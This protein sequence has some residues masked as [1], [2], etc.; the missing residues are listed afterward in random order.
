MKYII[1]IFKYYK[2]KRWRWKW[3][4]RFYDDLYSEILDRLQKEKP[5]NPHQNIAEAI[6][7]T[8]ST[9]PKRGYWS[10]K[11][12]AY[13]PVKGYALSPNITTMR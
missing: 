10:P 8:V 5:G 4:H 3:E 7:R 9:M 13:L 1:V 12:K 6:Q 2:V 11:K